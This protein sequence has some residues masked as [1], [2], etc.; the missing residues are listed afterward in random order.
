MID[1]ENTIIILLILL[2]ILCI[3]GIVAAIILSLNMENGGKG[4]LSKIEKL[5]NTNR[6]ESK[7]KAKRHAYN[8]NISRNKPDLKVEKKKKHLGKCDGDCKN[9]P[10]HYGYRYGRWYYGHNHSEGCVFGGNSCSG[11]R[12]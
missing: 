8:A 7:H 4:D 11:G 5:V 1:S 9:C 12:D 10:P 6:M 2:L 3:G